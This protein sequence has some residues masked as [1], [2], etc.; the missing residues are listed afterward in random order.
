MTPFDQ[1]IDNDADHT[2]DQDDLI[3]FHLREL[4]RQQKLAV[5]RALHTHPNLRA[6]SMAI[7]STLRAFPKHEAALPLDAATLDRHWLTL[8]HAL[9]IHIP[10]ATAPRSLFPRT[11]F[12]RWAIP[13][14][15]ASALAATA[16][17]LSLHHNQ[18][19]TSSTIATT[20]APSSTITNPPHSNPTSPSNAVAASSSI[21]TT[22]PS[23]P[24]FLNH[25][26]PQ[27]PHTSPPVPSTQTHPTPAQSIAQPI[28]TP[29]PAAASP[30]RSTIATTQQPTSLTSTTPPSPTPRRNTQPSSHIHHD[31]TT[32]LT[33][34]VIGNLTPGRS[35][36]ASTGTYTQVTTP[37]IGALASFHQQL[38]PWL[39]YRITTTYSRPTFEYTYGTSSTNGVRTL[40]NERIYEV[41]GTY[42]V[43][44]PHP[45]RITTSAEAGAG[46]LAFLASNPNV[47][48][49]PISNA[50]R[51]AGVVGASAELA[52]TKHWAVHLGYRA[53]LYKAP[54]NYPIYG[55]AVVQPPGMITVSSNP[56]V[57]ITYRFGAPGKD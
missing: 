43:Q 17:I 31:L 9:P 40:L 20:E 47:A 25:P 22:S 35:S 11:L 50:Y 27:P 18:R 15:A 30:A 16:L 44:G 6:E 42:A 54:A 37:A 8:R 49:E 5:L 14:F 36:T 21:P 38:R 26:S 45:R 7:A 19:S 56:I 28:I 23:H 13:A 3:A 52:L 32:D 12:S 51:P 33:L 34:A 1:N 10:P 46:L 29:P 53:L 57:G 2:I 24:P 39:G 55:S 41:S 48:N 4:P